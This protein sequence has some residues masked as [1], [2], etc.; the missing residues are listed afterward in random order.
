MIYVYMQN[1][2]FKED[3]HKDL[4]NSIVMID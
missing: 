4:Y 3:L 2:Q 1:N